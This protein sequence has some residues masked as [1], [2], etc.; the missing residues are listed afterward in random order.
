MEISRRRAQVVVFLICATALVVAASWRAEAQSGGA[1]TINARAFGEAA[2]AEVVVLKASAEPERVATGP[3]GRPISVPNGSYDVEITCTELID[4]P[5]K[6]LRGVEVSGEMAE[7]EVTFP[8]GVVTLR[9]RRGGR[10]LNN[11]TLHFTRSGGEDVVGT[12]KTGHPFL[13]SPGQYEAEI[14]VGRGR[15]KLAHSITGIQ[16]YAGAK[17][18]IPV[19]L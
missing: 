17:R 19:S 18:N 1:I 9:V 4:H 6:R 5:T 10:T 16:V 2:K 13:A 14:I 7:R 8:A 11:A 12:A 3:A 15:S